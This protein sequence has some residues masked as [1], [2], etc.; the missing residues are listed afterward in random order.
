MLECKHQNHFSSVID[1]LL[2]TQGCR[3]S[4]SFPHAKQHGLP[5]NWS[6]KLNSWMKKCCH[7]TKP[8]Q[9]NDVDQAPI[10][11]KIFTVPFN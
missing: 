7:G 6:G 8:L 2:N 9:C 11:P 5:A 1:L 3:K 4:T 10:K